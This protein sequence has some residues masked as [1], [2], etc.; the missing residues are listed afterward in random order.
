MERKF[1]SEMARQF[2]EGKRHKTSRSLGLTFAAVAVMVMFIGATVFSLATAVKATPSPVM[3]DHELLPA[4]EDTI[5]VNA[6]VAAKRVVNLKYKSV[7]PP[8]DGDLGVFR[9][10]YAVNLM[11]KA[12]GSGVNVGDAIGNLNISFDSALDD[13]LVTI[14]AVATIYDP[15]GNSAWSETPTVRDEASSVS[16]VLNVT[17]TIPLAFVYEMDENGAIISSTPLTLAPGYSVSITIWIE[18]QDSP[19]LSGGV[20]EQPFPTIHTT[21][22]VSYLFEKYTAE[23]PYIDPTVLI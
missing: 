11:I 12:D 22:G 6:D 3:D 10:T 1:E 15:E 16:R 9:F 8:G 17:A 5:N 19:G 2:A 23:F 20:V 7:S 21:D 14:S 18:I 4:L 13:S